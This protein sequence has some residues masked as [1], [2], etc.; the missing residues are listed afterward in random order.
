MKTGLADT[1]VVYV[2]ACNEQ[3]I[4]A[5]LLYGTIQ[6][7]RYNLQQKHIIQTLVCIH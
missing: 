1:N 7:N 5:I 4:N 3:R 6:H 2:R